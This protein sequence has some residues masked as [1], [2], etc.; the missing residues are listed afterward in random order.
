MEHSYY[1]SC[2]YLSCRSS[3]WN[4]CH[5]CQ[6]HPHR[7]KYRS[8]RTGGSRAT[9]AIPYINFD[10]YIRNPDK[11]TLQAPE[12]MYRMLGCGRNLRTLQGLE[13]HLVNSHYGDLVAIRE[14]PGL[15]RAI[16]R[17]GVVVALARGSRTGGSTAAPAQAEVGQQS[18]SHTL[19]S[20]TTTEIPTD[21]PYKPQSSY[22]GR[23]AVPK[24]SSC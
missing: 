17:R 8:T 23:Q 4:C 16:R 2:Q 20:T 21:P 10:D 11:S 3:S 6:R 22:T 9:I 14:I 12:F 1:N 24:S 18:G 15:C 13:D 5:P 19:T 7:R